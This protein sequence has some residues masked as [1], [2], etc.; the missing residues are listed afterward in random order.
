MAHLNLFLTNNLFFRDIPIQINH[1]HMGV[2]PNSHRDLLLKGMDLQAPTL[3]ATIL[4]QH[5]DI[6]AD[7]LLPG[8]PPHLP[9]PALM[10]LDLVTNPGMAQ[11]RSPQ[12]RQHQ[13]TIATQVATTIRTI[14]LLDLGSREDMPLQQLNPQL[15]PLNRDS[16]V[17]QT[18]MAQIL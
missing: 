11:G 7:P 13:Q 12:S 4:S 17:S 3:P 15:R 6:I 9:N 18:H 1:R 2:H 10:V 5:K 14:I 8:T 16:P